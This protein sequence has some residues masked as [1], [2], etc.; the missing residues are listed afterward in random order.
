MTKRRKYIFVSLLLVLVILTTQCGTIAKK[1]GE[2]IVEKT[3]AKYAYPDAGTYVCDEL[4][5]KLTFDGSNIGVTYSDGRNG[6]IHIHNGGRM[7]AEGEFIAFYYWD[8]NKNILKVEFSQSSSIPQNTTYYFV[9][10]NPSS[11]LQRG[12][13]SSH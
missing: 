13:R 11:G 1:V 8:Q 7:I 2:F 6:K 5:M 3:A 10:D 9:V 4:Q 12:C